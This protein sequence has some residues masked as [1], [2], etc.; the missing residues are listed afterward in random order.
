V[1]AQL[2]ETYLIF[3]L[4]TLVGILIVGSYGAIAVILVRKFLR[5]RNTGFILLGLATVIW[6]LV[7]LLVLHWESKIV[8]RMAISGFPEFFPF[9]QAGHA[10]I[11]VGSLLELLEA[12][13]RLVGVVLL[14]AAVWYLCRP[15]TGKTIPQPYRAYD[16]FKAAA[17]RTNFLKASSSIFSPS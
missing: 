2:N 4:F 10:G 8:A 11:S 7:H 14:L 3:G 9:G 12:L 15:V 17:S 5:T 6:P 1:V 13:E 16:P